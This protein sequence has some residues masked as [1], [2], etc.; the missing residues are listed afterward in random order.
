MGY[1][2]RASDIEQIAEKVLRR[3]LDA[4]GL[5]RV[6]V[7]EERDD[8]DDQ[9][10]A[11]D[12]VMKPGTDVLDGAIVS[13]AHRALRRALLD[14]G[15]DRFPYFMIRHSDDEQPEASLPFEVH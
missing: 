10:L 12:A 13:G 1:T 4:S 9:V 15:E 11:V 7:R 3:E 5:E 14:A 2:M 6:V 8:V